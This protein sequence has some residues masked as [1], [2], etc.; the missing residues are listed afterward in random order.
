[1]QNRETRNLCMSIYM[2]IFNEIIFYQ[3]GIKVLGNHVVKTGNSIMN[4]RG[5]IFMF[6]NYTLAVIYM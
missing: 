3:N 6:L 1:M 2:D 4:I 5:A